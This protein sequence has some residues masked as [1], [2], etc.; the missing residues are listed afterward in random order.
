MSEIA[1]LQHV[2]NQACKSLSSL[3]AAEKNEKLAEQV[4]L[5]ANYILPNQADTATELSGLYFRHLE[6]EKALQF[7]KKSID[8]TQGKNDLSYLNAG[9]IAAD[10]GMNQDALSYYNNA[11]AIDEK[12]YRAKFGIA[13]EKLKHGNYKEGWSEYLI[14]HKAFDCKNK[15]K[16]LQKLPSWN[17]KDFGKIIFYNEQGYGDFIFALR[18]L[19][20]V[21]KNLNDYSIEADKNIESFLKQT[22][23]SAFVNKK[24]FRAKFKCSLLDLPGLLGKYGYY[25]NFYADCIKQWDKQKTQ[26]K[27]VAVVFSGS[28][29]YNADTRRSM[30]LSNLQLL[31]DTSNCE[32][33]IFN[34]NIEG[35]KYYDTEMGSTKYVDKLINFS[36][37]VDFLRKMDCLVTVDTA[38]AHIGGAIGIPTCVLLN[39]TCDFRWWNTNTTTKWYKSWKLFRQKKLGCWDEPVKKLKKYLASH[40][41]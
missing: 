28:P 4:L 38:M 21:D 14:R 10:L 32:F 40:L 6:M 39:K 41:Q 33:Y 37:T 19:Q 7:A 15:N 36:A 3:Y 20:F 25:P 34:K 35:N 31:Q 23:Y 9:I 27:K 1:R 13:I 24:H 22:K 16:K 5:I 26:R 29:D 12:C 18:Y 30:A 2:I 17:G 11:L 8:L